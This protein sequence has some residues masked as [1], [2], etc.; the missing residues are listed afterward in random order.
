MYPYPTKHVEAVDSVMLYITGLSLILLIG[1]T[2]LMV[3]FVFRYHR[4]RGHKPV[5]IHGNALL[6]T[7][8]IVIPTIIVMTMFY[9]G[10]VGF[11]DSRTIPEGAF[12]VNVTARMW[13]WDFTYPNNVKTDTLYVPVNTPVK[14]NMVSADVNHSLYIPAFRIKEDVIMGRNTYLGFTAENLGS[15]DIA[16][17]EYC[18]LQH[19]QMYTKLVVLPQDT[20]DKWYNKDN[21]IATDTTKTDSTKVK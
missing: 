16:C 14:L 15:F 20:F 13:A 1:I 6:E 8:W 12:T 4:K 11:Q 17:A 21:L 18:G 2:I 7:V 3:Y 5:D 9:S 10:Y 19:S